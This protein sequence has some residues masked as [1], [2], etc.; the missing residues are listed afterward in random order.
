MKQNFIG[1]RVGGPPFG[2]FFRLLL[3]PPP[4]THPF[5]R[6]IDISTSIYLSIY[7]CIY[8]YVYLDVQMCRYI[9]CT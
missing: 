9:C 7:L 1:K 8:E 2:I 4:P 6:N 3:L 5:P